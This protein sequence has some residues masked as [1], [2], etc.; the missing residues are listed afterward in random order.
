MYLILVKK[1]QIWQKLSLHLSIDTWILIS[2]YLEF[3]RRTLL[4]LVE[5]PSEFLFIDLFINLIFLEELVVISHD[6]FS[7]WTPK[8]CWEWNAKSYF[9]AQAV[10]NT[11][12]A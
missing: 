9:I 5:K 1:S 3:T 2:V 12:D 7:S 10:G 6:I 4:Y 8:G 11:N